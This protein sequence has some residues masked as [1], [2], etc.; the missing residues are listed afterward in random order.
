MY[1]IKKFPED[2]IVGE[3]PDIKLVPQGP[4]LICLLKKRN[5]TT[6]RAV[7]QIAASLNIPIDRIGYA[8]SKDK[9][10]VAFQ[11]ISLRAVPRQRADLQNLKDISLSF[12]GYSESPLFLGS[13]VGNSFE[14][15]I[16]K[17]SAK[18]MSDLLAKS[19]RVQSVP[20]YFGEQR[21]SKGN[22]MIGKLLVKKDFRQAA[23]SIRKRHPEY[24]R[25]GSPVTY[26]QY[27]PKKL[28]SLYIHSYQSLL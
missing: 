16:R 5:Y 6:L 18:Q 1:E 27:I 26:L 12:Q 17:L 4:Y 15:R 8:G 13:L 25:E 19:G 7:E 22:Q 10:A 2:F 28:L 3:M 14:I 21:F 20:N 23:A 24:R 9:N 11:F